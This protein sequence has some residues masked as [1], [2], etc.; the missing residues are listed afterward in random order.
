MCLLLEHCH[1][2]KHNQV[3]KNNIKKFY[4]KHLK[5]FK[6]ILCPDSKCNFLGL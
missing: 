3:V 2:D 1:F 6:F 5:S 4:L